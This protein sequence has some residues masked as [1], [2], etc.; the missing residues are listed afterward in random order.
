MGACA[1]SASSNETPTPIAG[2]V[3]T[4]ST[5]YYGE[6]PRLEVSN[7]TNFLGE[8]SNTGAYT[9]FGSVKVEAPGYATYVG[10]VFLVRDQSTELNFTLLNGTCSEDCTNSYGRCNSACNGLLEC[11]FKGYD[12]VTVEETMN[13]CNNVLGGKTMLIKVKNETHSWYVDCCMG[14]PYAKYNAKADTSG[15]E[16]IKNLIKTEK[17][18]RYG[19]SPSRLIIAYW[20]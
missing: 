2:A 4:F 5:T 16:N 1:R 11:S 9:G 6:G 12:N 10:D 20:R 18:V 19:Y 14:I 8:Y 3:V 15:N 13:T 17:I 7:T